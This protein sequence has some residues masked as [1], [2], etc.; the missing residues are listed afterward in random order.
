MPRLVLLGPQAKQPTLDAALGDL[1]PNGP[2]AAVTAGWQERESED[3]ELRAHVGRDVVNLRLWERC[4]RMFG[5]DP[6]LFSAARAR[7][8]ELQALQ[9]LYR[10][11]LSRAL[12]AARR[13]MA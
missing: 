5:A 12:D 10:L 6:E 11:R 8:D 13:L 1:S 4:E 2:L 3:D 9:R 7:Q